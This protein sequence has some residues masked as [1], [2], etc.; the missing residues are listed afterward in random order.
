M[1]SPNFSPLLLLLGALFVAFAPSFARAKPEDMPGR[2]LPSPLETTNTCASCHAQLADAK[3]RAPAKELAHS[4]H[5]DERIGCV[6][7]HRGDAQDPTVAAHKGA[8]FTPHPTHAEVPKIC[9]GCPS[10]AAFM[11]TING[12]ISVGQYALYQL[13]LHGKLSAA[14]DADAPTCA[15]CHGQHDIVSPSSPTAPVNRL[16]VAKLCGGCH[17]DK[18]RMAKYPIPTDQ[19]EKWEHSVH[20]EAFRKGN[21][22][23]PTCTGCHG[24]HSSAPPDTS[25]VARACGR[26]HEEEMT[27]FE[28]SPHSKGFRERGF[29]QCVV[30]HSN[31]DVAPATELL[32]GT[33]SNAT[34]MRCHSKDDKPRQVAGDISAMLGGARQ[35]AAEARDAV[36]RASDVG[37][38]VSGAQYSLDKLSTAELKLRAVVHTL[39]PARVRARADDVDHHADEAVRLVEEAQQSRLSERRGYFVALALAG[40]L[41]VLLWLKAAQLDRRRTERK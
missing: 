12:R 36:K 32:V 37:L 23:A 14:G 39:D 2:A 28:Q 10:D 38:H 27:F 31:H 40:V 16:N 18:A 4:V 17:S 33:S 35:K 29:A 11:R 9:G 13:S 6:G 1:R 25:S 5:R 34:C 19:F 7:C 30:C 15:D 3:L 22:N 20:G 24:A 8:G 41:F 21:A 26:C